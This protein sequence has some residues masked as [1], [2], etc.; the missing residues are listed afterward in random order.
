[1]PVR[2]ACTCE[3]THLWMKRAIFPAQF[4]PSV[5]WWSCLRTAI[6]VRDL[7]MHPRMPDDLD[8]SPEGL[9]KTIKAKNGFEKLIMRY[10][11]LDA[12]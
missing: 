6:K 7:L 10:I 3:S 8:I 12:A 2:Y 1:M 5:E 4:D 11:E 9:I